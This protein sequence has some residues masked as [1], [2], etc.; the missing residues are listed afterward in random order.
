MQSTL[1]RFTSSKFV[2]SYLRGE[3]YLSSLSSFWDISQG[4]IL[5]GK[6]L[7]VEEMAEIIN[8]TPTDRQDFSEGVIAQI[9][10]LSISDLFESL[11]DYIIHDIR[12][13]LSA[14]K[15][16][17][18]L[19]FFRIDAEDGDAGLLDEENA[20]YILQSKGI[21]ITADELRSLEP[22]RAQKLVMDNIEANPLL[23]SDKVHA[24][25]LPSIDMND[26]G[27]AAIVIKN[28]AELEKRVKDAVISAGGRVILGDIR[29]HPMVDRVDPTTMNRH[30]ITV[31]SSDL[32]GDGNNGRNYAADGTFHISLLDNV[33]DI[34]W[35]GSLDKYD[36]YA[37]QKE[38]R[39][40]W[41]PEE[42][43]YEAKTL[44]VGS[45]EDIID[46][47]ETKNIRSYLLN[48]YK[49]YYPG[50]IETPRRQITGTC[51]YRDFKEYIKSI[52]GLGDFVMEIG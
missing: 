45:L 31:I 40:C 50:I 2:E 10:R 27:D 30:S 1:I 13:R 32:R 5:Y 46:V 51:S 42:R 12:F 35:R 34:Y 48:K 43:N 19:C 44:S 22:A 8:N 16:C 17:N 38:W 7:T 15:Y 29:Y 39:I 52:D 25:Q 37:R 18:L 47:V 24:V 28:Q 49:G 26:F 14:Y 36:R 4:K 33:E 9:P 23:S 41:L 6:K 11:K 21:N 3:L 20:A